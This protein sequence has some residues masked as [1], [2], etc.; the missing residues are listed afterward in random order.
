MKNSARRGIRGRRNADATRV[1]R[2][3]YTDRTGTDGARTRP[4]GRDTNTEHHCRTG[5]SGARALLG[6]RRSSNAVTEGSVGLAGRQLSQTF[7]SELS[8]VFL[9]GEMTNRSAAHIG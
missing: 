2:H 7:E 4:D 1:I 3:G 9:T 6:H 8:A 5:E